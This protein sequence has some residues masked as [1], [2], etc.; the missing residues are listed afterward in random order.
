MKYYAFKD[1]ET[2]KLITGTDYN[3]GI[4]QICEPKYNSPLLIPRNDTDE[5]EECDKKL[6]DLML[7]NAIK[8]RHIDLTKYALVKVEVKEVV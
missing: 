1:I 6:T 7:G 3:D 2:G 8:G 5:D 4:K